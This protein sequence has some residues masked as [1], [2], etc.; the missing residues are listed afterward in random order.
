MSLGKYLFLIL[1]IIAA[2][3]VSAQPPEAERLDTT[4]S[5]F[6]NPNL[7]LQV[8]ILDPEEPDTRKKNTVLTLYKTE[9]GSQR[10]LYRDSIF[11]YT[12]Q[13]RMTDLNGDG[14]KDLL[15]YHTSNG[16]ENRSFHLFLVDQKGERLNRVRG[17]EK[18]FNPYYDQS[19]CLILGSESLE[20]KLTLN[21]YQIDKKGNLSLT[22]W[23]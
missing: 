23:R 17:F 18:V 4:L 9:Q 10:I 5:P 20:K 11:A 8:R 19:G 22:T 15:V 14:I 3:P 1:I 2:G 7:K 13:F 16:P 12:L 21:H 6:W